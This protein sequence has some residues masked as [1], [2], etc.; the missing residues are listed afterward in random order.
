MEK[1]E[2]ELGLALSSNV[3]AVSREAPLGVGAEGSFARP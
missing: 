1:L 3:S 2:V